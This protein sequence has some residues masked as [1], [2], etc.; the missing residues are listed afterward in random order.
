MSYK[1]S[2]FDNSFKWMCQIL[3]CSFESADGIYIISWRTLWW[4]LCN[5]HI[6][7]PA[8]L[9][10]YTWDHWDLSDYHFWLNILR[11]YVTIW[12]RNLWVFD[13]LLIRIYLVLLELSHK[14]LLNDYFHNLFLRFRTQFGAIWQACVFD[15]M[16][17]W[18]DY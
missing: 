12:L 9:L 1:N 11:I 15:K 17:L 3:T 4:L 8:L 14:N 5:D 7:D 13:D 16:L 18:F 2:N 10:I 6:L